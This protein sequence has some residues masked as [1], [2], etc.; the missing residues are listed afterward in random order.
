MKRFFS[1]LIISC[2]LFILS[3]V[4]LFAITFRQKIF[5]SNSVTIG[6]KQDQTSQ[7]VAEII[8]QMTEQHTDLNVKRMIGLEGAFCFQSLLSRGIDLYPEYTGTA[9]ENFLHH[10]SLGCGE[11]DLELVQQLSK[12]YSLKWLDPLGFEEAYTFIATSN[13]CGE[14][15]VNSMTSLAEV[16]KK[17]EKV[18]FGIDPEFLNRS[19]CKSFFNHYLSQDQVDYVSLD[20]SIAYLALIKGEVDV[21]VGYTNDFQRLLYPLQMIPD[22]KH[23][24]PSYICCPLIQQQVLEKHPQLHVVFEKLRGR[25]SISKV[26]K[27]NYTV[28]K[29]RE[30]IYDVAR[31]FL[32]EENLL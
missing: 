8:A 26:Q 15:G 7:I 30:N 5:Y 10:D 16:I 23:I 9:L 17:G 25:I 1:R 29:D 13:F 18:R 22:D 2:T 32:L 31:N 12:A 20:H 24:F 6:G 11:Q 4:V 3:V 28:E 27:M 21:I 14:K 19:E